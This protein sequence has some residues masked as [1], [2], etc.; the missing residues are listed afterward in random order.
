MNTFKNLLPHLYPTG[1]GLLHSFARRTSFFG[2]TCFSSL[3]LSI[4]QMQT[5]SVL[6]C[7]TALRHLSSGG[8]VLTLFS[9]GVYAVVEDQRFL[10]MTIVIKS[11]TYSKHGKYSSAHNKD[12]NDYFHSHCIVVLGWFCRY[13]VLIFAWMAWWLFLFIA[14]ENIVYW[15][16]INVQESSNGY[17]SNQK[18]YRW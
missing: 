14:M 1:T 18:S 5:M 11:F 17:Q 4:R 12:V 10:W 7:S 3:G 8:D 2:S 9:Y 16:S 15:T 13:L 6:S